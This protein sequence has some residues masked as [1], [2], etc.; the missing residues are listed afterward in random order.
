[1][2]PRCVNSYKSAFD[3]DASSDLFGVG[4]FFLGAFAFCASVCICS[5]K[6]VTALSS[7]RF[8]RL[9]P[10]PRLTGCNPCSKRIFIA[11]FGDVLNNSATAFLSISL[12]LVIF[13]SPI[14]KAPM[15]QGAP[16]KGVYFAVTQ[17]QRYHNRE[18][19]EK[20]PIGVAL[21]ST[22]AGATLLYLFF[23]GLIRQKFRVFY[24]FC[25]YSVAPQRA[26]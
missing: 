11:V 24:A 25:N 5:I 12:Q 3:N 8:P 9:R 21:P 2:I 1:M 15:F 20:K 16:L 10:A 23:V 7:Q 4:Y 17:K 6:A 14:K 19:M 22:D 18:I 13:S 26:R